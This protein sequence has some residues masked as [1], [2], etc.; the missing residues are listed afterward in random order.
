MADARA[1][2]SKDLKA[3]EDAED[4][5]EARAAERVEDRQEAA[6]LTS[7]A[8]P[9]PPVPFNP[10]RVRVLYPRWMTAIIPEVGEVS[11][12]VHSEEQEA[13]VKERT[14]TFKVTKSAQG[15]LYEVV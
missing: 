5:A 6:R 8:V 15:D 1:Q 13:A 4:A 11:L 9:G 12:V 14:A 3:Q 10:P 2:R 7:K